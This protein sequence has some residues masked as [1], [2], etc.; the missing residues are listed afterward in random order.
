[1]NISMKE[2]KIK[3]L[4]NL[5]AYRSNKNPFVTIDRSNGKNRFYINASACN[6]IRKKLNIKDFNYIKVGLIKEQ[7]ILIFKPVFENT[8]GK[9]IK[10][11]DGGG[12]SQNV[13]SKTFSN[14]FLKDK[15]KKYLSENKEF[16]RFKVK[17]NN[18]YKG[19]NI[20]LN[21]PLVNSKIQ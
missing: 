21:E 7:K 9:K 16:K 19:L 10:L 15:I 14:S 18:N 4:E 5:N 8:E 3:W 11:S 17:W 12:G 6:L 1:M 20:F 2:N 13:D